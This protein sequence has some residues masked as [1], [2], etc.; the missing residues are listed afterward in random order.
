MDNPNERDREAPNSG[1]PARP[2]AVSSQPP[3][4]GDTSPTPQLQPP[5]PPPRHKP[6][7]RKWLWIGSG[8][9]V[10]G[11]GLW[12]LIPWVETALNTISTDDAYVNG[13]VTLVA[14]RVAGQVQRVLADD[15]YHVKAGDVLIEI[16]KEPYQVQVAIQKAVVVQAETDLTAA[17]AQVRSLVGQARAN[18]FKLEHA[19]EDVNAQIAKVRAD[20]ATLNSEKA[21]LALARAN[22][23]R[24]E[25]LA[26]SGGISKE[27]LDQRRQAVKVEEAAVEQAL[28]T[29]YADRVGLGLPAKP[30]AGQ[31]LAEVPANLDQTFST[32]RAALGDLLQ[33]GTQIGYVPPSWTATPKEILDAFYKQSPT[34]NL[35]Q[36]LARM[37]PN[38][39][40]VKQAEARLLKARSDL[41]QAELNLRYCDVVSAIDGVVTRRNVNP[42]DY[43]AVG[44]QLMAVRSLTEIWIDANF[45]ETQL[46]DL[47]IGQH[48]RIEIDTYG[49]QHEFHGRIT[50]FTMGTGQ[51]LA[52][53]PPEN[54]TGNF[55]KIVQRLPVRIDLTDYDPDQFTL[56]VGLS[57]I[58]YVCYKEPPT[59]PNAGKKLQAVAPL[60]RAPINPRP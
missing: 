29:V 37:I 40:A 16:D 56:F 26:P 35:N 39:P 38:A 43:V 2:G 1:R 10:L 5:A 18:R 12:F 52:L 9:V 3:P 21:K 25:E 8:A 23:K 45:K 22:F 30:P 27:E 57:A 34:G 6:S 14:P 50:G 24:G 20:V 17:R 53:L 28:Q 58:P 51:T 55:V 19:I 11:I 15:N 54:A 49:K 36:I 31:D 41:E 44:Q 13:H 33:V 47:R 7:W 32:V 46:A 59:G 60:P 48:V 4:P 42:G